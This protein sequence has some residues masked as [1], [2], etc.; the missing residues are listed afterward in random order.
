M[1]ARIQTQAFLVSK[2]VGFLFCLLCFKLA[3]VT[4]YK[5]MTYETAEITKKENK[6][7][8]VLETIREETMGAQVEAGLFF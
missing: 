2:S 3:Q 1:T 7:G 4:S 8:L 6:T 5:R